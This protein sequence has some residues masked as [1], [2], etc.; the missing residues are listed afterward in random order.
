M[1][2]RIQFEKLGAARFTSHKDVVRIFQRCLAASGIPVAYSEGFHPHMKMSFGPPL[3]TGWESDAE[4]LDVIVE[5]A[6]GPLADLCNPILPEGLRIS[7]VSIVPEGTP[8]LAADISAATY[9]VTIQARDGLGTDAVSADERRAR[10]ERLE[11]RIMDHAGG[12]NEGCPRVVAIE[13]SDLSDRLE[14]TYTS[15]ML[16]GRVVVPDDL[17]AATIGDPETFCTPLRIRR[18]AQFVERD[19]KYLSPISRGVVSKTS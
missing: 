10:L 8:K 11:R 19:G 6:P 17:V 3:R 9:R 1:K 5:R 7:H 2:L 12:A 18:S 4:F 13:T 16:S 15:T 14:I